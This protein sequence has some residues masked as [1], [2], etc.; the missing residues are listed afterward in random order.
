MDQILDKMGKKSKGSRRSNPL[1]KKCWIIVLF[2]AL[3]GGAGLQ[4]HLASKNWQPVIIRGKE[5]EEVR[6]EQLIYRT[7][8]GERQEITIPVYPVTR[9]A[10]E[11]ADLLNQAV[12]EWEQ[13][14]LGK[15]KTADAVRQSLDLPEQLQNGLVQVSYES[16]NCSVLQDDGTLVNEAVQKDGELIEL[17][18][19]FTYGSFRREETRALRVLPPEQGSEEWETQQ[20]QQALTNREAVT[21]SQAQIELPEQIG[22][23]P[24]Q[25]ERE[26]SF[27][28]I[29]LILLGPIILFCLKWKEKQDIQKAE[30]QKKK[31]LMWEYPSMVEQMVLLLGSGM[32]VFAAWEKILQTSRK[33]SESKAE[34][35]EV[36]QKRYLEEM[37]ITKREISEGMGE[38]RAY[39]RF[40][41]RI[42]LMPYRRF[43]AILAQSLS[44]G[45]QDLQKMLKDEVAE[46]FEIRK[47][48][49]RR[50]G[51]EA[52]TK[53]LFPMMLMFAL[54]LVIL[55][56]PALQ[57]F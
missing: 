56:M 31:D 42:G 37:W 43:S 24:V 30:E 33:T 51:E 15:N 52:G 6:E 46:A 10:K 28:W 17:T 45:R 26:R 57:K 36:T 4:E 39:E 18:A 3:G 11:A 54:I 23:I 14:Y 25:W 48:N 27:T 32:T 19:V 20:I 5:G 49:A 40:G 22:G 29:Y 55:L 1:R 53:L 47:N 50:R 35:R 38:I 44:K 7:Q 2:V 34:C 9:N 8:D 41:E 13:Q 21:R 16:S 12:K